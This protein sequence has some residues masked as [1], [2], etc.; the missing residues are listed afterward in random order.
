[1]AFFCL[2]VAAECSSVVLVFMGGVGLG[3][4]EYKYLAIHKVFGWFF[5]LA[6]SHFRRHE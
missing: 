1:M 2:D 6:P 3:V 5:S 4:L